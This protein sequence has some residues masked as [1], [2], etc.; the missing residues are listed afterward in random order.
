M[1][2]RGRKKKRKNN[3]ADFHEQRRKEAGAASTNEA[4][5]N[6]ES[7]AGI[8]LASIAAPTLAAFGVPLHRGDSVGDACGVDLEGI[9]E[10]EGKHATPERSK[11]IKKLGNKKEGRRL[12]SS[13]SADRA[14]TQ[15][16]TCTGTQN[17]L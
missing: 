2:G 13:I 8:V 3:L 15:I 7:D 11:R 1:A 10:E 14:H 16:P 17:P 9:P 6:H 4:N 12:C 5:M